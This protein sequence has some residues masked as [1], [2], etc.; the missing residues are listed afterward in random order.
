MNALSR[1]TGRLFVE[2]NLSIC[3]CSIAVSD[4]F[5]TPWTVA[6]QVPLSMGFFRQ[7]DGSRL[8]FSPPGDLPN[9]RS[10]PHLPHGQTDSLPLSQQGSPCKHV[11]KVLKYNSMISKNLLLENNYE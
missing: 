1:Y 9:Q 3:Y 10:N 4:S 11:L 5:V 7:E 6:C 2:C 8:P